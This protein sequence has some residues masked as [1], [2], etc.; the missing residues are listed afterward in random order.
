MNKIIILKDNQ[1]NTKTPIV[2]LL[3]LVYYYWAVLFSV[4]KPCFHAQFMDLIYRIICYK[5]L[6]MLNNYYL[7][8]NQK[9]TT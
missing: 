4:I 3:L 7:S 9:K 6:K 1:S 2:K 5:A 8:T